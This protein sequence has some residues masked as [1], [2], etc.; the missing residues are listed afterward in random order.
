MREDRTGR[1]ARG[2][3]AT[4]SSNDDRRDRLDFWWGAAAV[5]VQGPDP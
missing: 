3:R 1:Y 5:E 2:T 4:T